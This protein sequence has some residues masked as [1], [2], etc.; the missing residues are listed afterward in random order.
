MGD[1]LS[2]FSPDLKRPDTVEKS[3][4]GWPQLDLLNESKEGYLFSVIDGFG[5]LVR[6][7]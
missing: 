4:T 5:R 2:V 1:D 3:L 6:H 7:G